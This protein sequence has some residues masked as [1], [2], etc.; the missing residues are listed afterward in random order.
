LYAS[1]SG[2]GQMIAAPAV[3]GPAE[4]ILGRLGIGIYDR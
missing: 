4:E 1:R 2:H 3:V